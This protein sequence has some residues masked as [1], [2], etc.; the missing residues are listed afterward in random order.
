M[1]TM[2]TML[3]LHMIIGEIPM[4]NTP[5]QS[6]PRHGGMQNNMQ[7]IIDAYIPLLLCTTTSRKVSIYHDWHFRSLLK[8]PHST[9]I[10]V[11]FVVD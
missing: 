3:M 11:G 10:L 5:P 4:I 2:L 7:P 1:T 8:T 9:T 6:P